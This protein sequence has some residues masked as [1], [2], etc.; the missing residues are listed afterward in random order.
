M[1]ELYKGETFT[2]TKRFCD[3]AWLYYRQFAPETIEGDE[4]G[5][6]RRLRKTAVGCVDGESFFATAATKKY[7]DAR[8]R[9]T[10][11]L[12]MTDTPSPD[13]IG[14][15]RYTTV[16]G[17]GER[18]CAYLSSIRRR[19]QLS[20]LTKPAHWKKLPPEAKEQYQ[21]Q[22]RADWLYTLCGTP[23]TAG[24]LYQKAGPIMPRR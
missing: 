19:T 15:P 1:T 17:A 7:T 3:I 18:G 16:L 9:R 6:H 23:V 4:S 22:A 5:L 21:W 13:T 14:L 20:L 8:L 12:A 2:D 24:D 10:A 11:L